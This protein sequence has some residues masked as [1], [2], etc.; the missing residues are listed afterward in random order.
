MDA[1]FSAVLPA[2][3]L[4]PDC[5]HV[6][7]GA[8]WQPARRSPTG[9]RA[10]KARV[11]LRLG[12]VVGQPFLAAAAFPSGNNRK[13]PCASTTT[14]SAPHSLCGAA[15]SGCSRLSVGFSH[16]RKHT[17]LT[18]LTTHRLLA[19]TL[20]AA[21]LL[22]AP[23]PTWLEK[24]TPILT[25]TERKAYLSL[26]PSE[27]PAFEENLWATRSISPDE[28]F[29]R[30]EHA[31]ALWGG[32]KTGSSANTDPGRVYLALGSPTRTTRIPSSRTFVPIEIWYYDTVP[33]VISTELRL[34]FYRPN[35]M[36][37]PK[38]YSP[39]TDT[40]R[41]LLV[42]Q[43]AT[44]HA[45]GPN[46][47]LTESDIRK[48]LKVAT[49]EDEVVTAA[50]AVASGIKGN[51]NQE[52]LGLVTSPQTLLSRNL[53]PKVTSRLVASHA[54]LESL[55]TPSP[56]GG[57]Q[58]D[59]Q[60][61]ATAAREIGLEIL[62]AD[63]TLVQ[64]KL[65][66]GFPASKPVEYRHR[67]DLLPGTYRI[68]FTADGAT[69]AFSLDVLD[70]PGMGEILR[71]DGIASSSP[72]APFIYA[73]QRYDPSP[74]GKFALTTLS[75][76]GRVTWIVRHGSQVVWRGASEG[77]DT[78]VVELPTNLPPGDYRLEAT[79]ANESKG[80]PFL[81]RPR[82]DEDHTPPTAV[83]YN[84]N[85]FPA[86]R[87]AFVG[88]QYLLR[89]HTPEARKSLEASVAQGPTTDAQVSLSRVDA[90]EGN[91]D[92]ARERIRAVLAASPNHFEALAVYAFIETRFQDYAVA[93]QLYRRALELQE[94]PAI[95]AALA[96]LP[97]TGR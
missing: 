35:S 62:S 34:L 74:E 19:A 54:Q 89:G 43:A 2:P 94:S 77:S 33:G 49:A 1:I 56:Y 51:G 60:F 96:N 11:W 57:M 50:V 6:R 67:L 52:I 36:G 14:P 91:L 78:A 65:Q 4:L 25:P 37:L 53:K 15:N 85:L 93:A 63:T 27:R 23:A 8:G 46:D 44:V 72:R 10:L 70:H 47:S 68:L 26:P 38:L 24:L 3:N 30:L 29:R 71:A 81:V 18:R 59:L 64:N 12:S 28:Y 17:N 21:T 42:P 5:N 92:G 20:L 61:R 45:F 48:I 7:C 40:I 31:D 95:R 79:T 87:N 84:A 41:E 69:S 83:S 88:R 75:H 90:L 73:D 22:A 16:P 13:S 86:L 97:S 76:P 9:A 82:N 39:Q 32:G 66:L 58:V 55:Q 80:T